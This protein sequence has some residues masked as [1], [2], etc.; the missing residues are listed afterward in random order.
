MSITGNERN[1]RDQMAVNI[2]ILSAGTR[3]KVVQYFVRSLA[4]IGS[5]TATDCS[6]LAPAIYDADRYYIVPR[7]TEPG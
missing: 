6:A 3:D 7:I 5:V 2:L 1:E 4:G